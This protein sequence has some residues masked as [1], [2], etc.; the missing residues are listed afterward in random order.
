MLHRRLRHFEDQAAIDGRTHGNLVEESAVDAD[1]RD[2]AEVAA[3]A[4][5]LPENLRG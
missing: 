1:D 2:D 4:D 3:T 5:G